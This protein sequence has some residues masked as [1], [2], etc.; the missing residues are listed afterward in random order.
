M[1]Y[2]LLLI[3]SFIIGIIGVVFGGSMF[4]SLPF[5]QFLFPGFNY[6]QIVGNVKVGSLVRGIA[7]SMSTW[8][9]IDFSSSLQI[10]IPFVISSILGTMII[11]KLDQKFLI[12]AIIGAI[13]LSESSPHIAHLINKK[14]RIFFSVLLGIYTGFIG[15]GVSILLVALLRTA[16]PK[17]E[18]IVFIKIQARFIEAAGAIA[19]VTAHIWYGNIIFPY[20]LVWSIGMFLGG[21]LGGTVLKRSLHLKAGTQRIYLYIVYLIALL[22]FVYRLVH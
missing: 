16:F 4:L 5:W 1:E 18:Q 13:F 2:I 10:L 19:A 17:N 20:W 11:A 9:K 21:Y 7:S 12:F 8:K 3:G 15:A 14:T 6:G 22:P